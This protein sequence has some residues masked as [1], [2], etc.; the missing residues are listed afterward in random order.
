MRSSIT[1]GVENIIFYRYP[2][3]VLAILQSAVFHFAL[4]AGVDKGILNPSRSA[5]KQLELDF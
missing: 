5:M 3:E 2:E 1:I 4:V